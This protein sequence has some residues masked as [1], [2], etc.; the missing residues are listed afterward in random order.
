[1]T[2]SSLPTGSTRH[3]PGSFRELLTVAVPLILSSS[4]LSLMHVID[5]V[6]LTWYSGDALAASAPA[7]MLNWLMMSVTLGTLTYVNTFVSQY[8]GADRP[9]RVSA[10]IWQ[11]V[12]LALASGVLFFGLAPLAPKIFA[13]IGHRPEVQRL[14]VEYFSVYCMGAVPICLAT[15]LSCFY[16]GR[17]E[18]H[19]VLYVDL[20]ACLVHAVFDW[21]LI[22]GWG[23][24]PPMG[25][26]G[27][28][29]ATIVAYVFTVAMFVLLMLRP[30]IRARYHPGRH[31]RLDLELLKRLARYGLPSGI[32]WFVDIAAFSMFI[33]VVGTIDKTSLMATNMAFNINSLAFIPMTGIGTAVLTLVGRR[34]GENRPDLAV[35]STWMAFS[36]AATWM[37]CFGAVFVL[38]PEFFLKIYSSYS[39]DDSIGLVVDETVVLLRFV[40]LYSFFD[41]MG[42]IFG[43]AVRGAG[44]TLFPLFIS[45]VVGWT[46]MVIPTWFFVHSDRPDRL[47]LSWWSCSIYVIIAGLGLMMRFQLGPWKRM[48][49]IES[50]SEIDAEKIAESE[51]PAAAEEAEECVKLVEAVQ[52]KVGPK[53]D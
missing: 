10:S 2:Q 24:I 11:G 32:H 7:G 48:R 39:K 33:F 16:S 27:A 41:G 35:R 19:V 52:K 51:G 47:I 38:A 40:A 31:W 34:I 22:F 36:I 45:A 20:A 49:V 37:L 12:Y 4:S 25:M 21:V 46:V 29:V 28:A 8:E 18:N 14:E 5:R 50:R 17:G 3:S 53:D 26:T 44:D 43:S 13:L 9:A 42:I 1:M 6:F 15:V 30:H 23:P